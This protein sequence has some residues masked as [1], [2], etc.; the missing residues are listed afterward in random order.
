M[1]ILRRQCGCVDVEA[2]GRSQSGPAVW[3]GGVGWEGAYGFGS[4]S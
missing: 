2:E 4:E 1:W 3:S